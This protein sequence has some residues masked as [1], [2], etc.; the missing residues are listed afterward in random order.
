[1]RSVAMK[2]ERLLG[3]VMG[4]RE[5]IYT[6]KLQNSASQEK[7]AGAELARQ[8]MC[9]ELEHKPSTSVCWLCEALPGTN[10]SL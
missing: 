10:S 4:S 5:N 9:P 3:E 2:T 7:S 1:M 6:R 8:G